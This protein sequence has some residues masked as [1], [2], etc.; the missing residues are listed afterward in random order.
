MKSSRN[1]V[2]RKYYEHV[3]RWA[4][5]SARWLLQMSVSHIR[6]QVLQDAAKGKFWESWRSGG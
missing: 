4:A 6:A 5:S 3:K 2:L 1:I